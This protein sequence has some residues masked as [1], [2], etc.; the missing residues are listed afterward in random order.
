M[1]EKTNNV[2]YNILIVF[3]IFFLS[4]SLYFLYSSYEYYSVYPK[5]ELLEF[6]SIKK[7]LIH[8]LGRAF[9]LSVCQMIISVPI[10]VVFK[11]FKLKNIGKII[12]ATL[13]TFIIAFI[14]FIY[15]FKIG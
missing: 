1:K 7:V 3:I 2:L 8:D 10:L 4:L 6:F 12:I 11:E 5:E 13:I 15:T 9:S 14:F